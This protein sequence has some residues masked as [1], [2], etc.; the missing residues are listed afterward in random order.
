MSIETGERDDVGAEEPRASRLGRARRWRWLNQLAAR[1]AFGR[2]LPDRLGGGALAVPE[3]R[4]F[5]IGSIVSNVGSWMQFVALSWLILQLTN[6]AFYLGLIGLVQAV[7]GISIT[8]VGGVLADRLDRRK[9]LLFTQTT[10]GLLALVLTALD[11]LHI[12]T[13]WEI[14]LIAFCSSAVGAIDN[15]TRQALIPDLVGED[16]IASAV[17]LNSAAWNGAAV[18]GPA[19]AGVLVALISTSGAFFLNGLS[20]FAVVWAV[21]IMRPRPRRAGP[22]RSILE[23]LTQGLT[24][25]RRDR[26]I[27]GLMLVMAIATLLGRPYTQLMPIFAQNVL[28]SGAS[29]YGVL[30]GASGV[31]ALVGA[32]LVAPLGG[33]SRKGFLMLAS[34]G[35]FGVSLLAFAGSRWFVV[36][37]AILLVVGLSQTLLMGMTNTLLQLNVPAE[38]RGRVMSAYTLIPSGVM[39]LGAMVLGGIGS[40]VGV[41]PTVA[42]GA[43]LVL[44]TSGAAYLTLGDVRTMP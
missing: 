6:S 38:M 35:L 20:Y 27:W 7:P 4:N 32:I 3:F 13:I 37:L 8:L 12:V 9:V 23:N 22:S 21:W 41:P 25:M 16:N 11:V 14:L 31:G 34:T 15:P 5:W 36:S 39:P 19:I 43:A 2:T 17:G 40:V 26:R 24:F 42:A 30:M 1:L 44:V 10:F 33:S 28:H 29:G 18:V